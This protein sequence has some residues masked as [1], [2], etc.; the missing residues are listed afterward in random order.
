MGC[1]CWMSGTYVEQA[2][3]AQGG[4]AERRKSIGGSFV[5]EHELEELKPHKDRQP[6][7]DGL[8]HLERAVGPLG[9]SVVDWDYT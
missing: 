6:T 3:L 1:Q 5:G 2:E 8:Q 7:Y 9:A 4:M